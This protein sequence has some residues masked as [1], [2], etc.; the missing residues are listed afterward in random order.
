MN[1]ETLVP[2]ELRGDLIKEAQITILQ[3]RTTEV[4][5]QLTLDDFKVFA[6]I[7]PTEY[8]DKLFNIKSKYGI[9]NLEKFVEVSKTWINFAM[10]Q[11]SLCL[12]KGSETVQTNFKK[13]F[14]FI[15]QL[16]NKEMYWVI[17]EVCS[18]PNVVKR[19][20]II[21]QFIKIASQ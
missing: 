7:Q 21:K 10:Y 20:R 17:T 3:L 5:S 13:M 18:E 8:I 11:R 4:A 15:F 14:Y 12:L 2:D 16:V 9:P 19:M 1:T 6:S